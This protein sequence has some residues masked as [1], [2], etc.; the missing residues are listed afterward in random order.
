[1]G[2]IT[3]VNQHHRRVPCGHWGQAP[4]RM[5]G[6][7]LLES[8]NGLGWDRAAHVKSRSGIEIEK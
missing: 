6:Q 2:G 7:N 4:S 8:H 1:M 3:V 5:R